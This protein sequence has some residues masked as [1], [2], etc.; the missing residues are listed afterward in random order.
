MTELS[1]IYPSL[2][3]TRG[4]TPTSADAPQQHAR[5]KSDTLNAHIHS[6][7][8]ADIVNEHGPLAPQA[9]LLLR[10]EA[11]EPR[12]RA[13]Q[14]RLGKVP[15]RWEKTKTQQ[16][17]SLR[18]ERVGRNTSHAKESL[19]T[20]YVSA[21]S[22]EPCLVTSRSRPKH[23]KACVRLQHKFACDIPRA[24]RE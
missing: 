7:L 21:F 17:T 12:G 22:L 3:R 2:D 5:G 15:R 8:L 13:L 6:D 10:R 9:R 19:T 14:L 11:I 18:L 4:H 23:K 24:E 16:D 20:Q 1:P